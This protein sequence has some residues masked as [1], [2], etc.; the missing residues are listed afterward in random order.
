VFS[1]LGDGESSSLRGGARSSSKQEGTTA[2]N[3]AAG[4][5][6]GKASAKKR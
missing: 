6:H 4:R 3:K 5:K 2:Q 1:A